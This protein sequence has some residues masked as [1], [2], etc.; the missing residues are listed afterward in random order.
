[1]GNKS[2]CLA[3]VDSATVS[4]RCISAELYCYGTYLINQ[5]YAD[6]GV[7]Y[8]SVSAKN[9]SLVQKAFST[10]ISE[11]IKARNPAYQLS[12][13]VKIA[14]IALCVHVGVKSY[15]V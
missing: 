3:D 10:L 8:F 15:L 6:E 13:K 7:A 5:L 1:M 2:D 12:H 14:F 11:V 9:G 4:T